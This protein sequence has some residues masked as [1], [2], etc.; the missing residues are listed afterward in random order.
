MSVRLSSGVGT[1]D[2]LVDNF[3]IRRVI[4][5]LELVIEDP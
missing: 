1:R 2:S 5:S 3:L 4:D